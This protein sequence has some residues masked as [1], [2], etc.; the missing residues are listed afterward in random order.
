VKY[1]IG[2]PESRFNSFE[3]ITNRE[4][5]I[6]LYCSDNKLKSLPDFSRL[7]SLG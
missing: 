4:K 1:E 3:E 5:I 6:Y 7:T 2:V